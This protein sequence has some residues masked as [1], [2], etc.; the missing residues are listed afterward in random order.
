MSNSNFQEQ[1]AAKAATVDTESSSTTNWYGVRNLFAEQLRLDPK[2]VYVATISKPGNV[3]PRF[4]Q[5]EGAVEASLLVGMHTDAPDK[6][7][8][9][10]AAAMKIAAK[11][12]VPAVVATREGGEWSVAVVLRPRGDESLEPLTECFPNAMVLPV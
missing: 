12:G 9:T 8:A 6:V 3:R 2:K 11:R 1:F 10:V 7:P 5:S 4:F